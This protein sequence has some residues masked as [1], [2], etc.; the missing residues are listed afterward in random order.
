MKCCKLFYLFYLVSYININAQLRTFE[1][2]MAPEDVEVS[3]DYISE[4]IVEEDKYTFIANTNCDQNTVFCIAFCQLT[5]DGKLLNFKK[6][7]LGGSFYTQQGNNFIKNSDGTYLFAGN[8]YE[9]FYDRVPV[10]MKLDKNLDTIWTK[11]YRVNNNLIDDVRGIGIYKN[12]DIVLGI[13]G[14]NTSYGD[15]GIIRTDSM[16]NLKWARNSGFRAKYFSADLKNM[17]LLTNGNILVSF[18]AGAYDNTQGKTDGNNFAI[19]D[20]MG[21][22]IEDHRI[23]KFL[24]TPPYITPL[25]DT[26]Y[27]YACQTD[28]FLNGNLGN[29]IHGIINIRGEKLYEYAFPS[30]ELRQINGIT[31]SSSG[32]FYLFDLRD[33]WKYGTRAY[34]FTKHDSTGKLLWERTYLEKSRMFSN[35]AGFLDLDVDTDGSLILSGAIRDTVQFHGLRKQNAFIMRF[36][37]DGCYFRDSCDNIFFLTKTEELALNSLINIYPNPANDKLTLVHN[38]KSIETLILT[39]FDITGRQLEIEYILMDNH[40]I[41]DTRQMVNGIYF[42]ALKAKNENAIGKFVVQ[43]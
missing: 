19:L 13:H 32:D 2:D 16:G 1:M 22:V 12:G 5:K 3:N 14:Y 35:M 25:T 6:Y 41:I 17:F 9:S 37:K 33:D 30:P 23:T 10:L 31:R 27:F 4:I 38:F 8:I 42:I 24:N 43:H 15:I 11:T 26:T 28:T 20:S 34:W 36:D 29:Q 39:T 18:F 7:K 21:R 40:I